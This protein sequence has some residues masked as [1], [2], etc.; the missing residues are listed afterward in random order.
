MGLARTGV[1][2]LVDKAETVGFGPEVLAELVRGSP[3]SLE[4]AAATLETFDVVVIQ[5][6]FGIYGGADGSEILDLMRRLS[7][8]VITVLHTVPRSPTPGQ[9]AIVEELSAAAAVVVAQSAAAKSRLLEAHS[10]PARHVR[11]IP[12]GAP[13]NLSPPGGSGSRRPIILSWGLLDRGK[14]IEYGIEAISHL[15]NLDPSP[16]YVVRGQTH[17]HALAREGEAYRELLHAQV[18][19]LGIEDLVE[20]YDSYDDTASVLAR[21][22]EA[23]VVLLPYRSRDQV[24]SGVLVEALASGKPVVATRFPHAVELLRDGSGIVVPH[25]DSPAIAAALRTLVTDP[26]AA[27]HAAAAARRQAPTFFWKNVGRMY[28]DLA[29]SVMRTRVAA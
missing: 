25:N 6:E 22:R 8:P 28:R 26:S 20:F 4:R 13:F 5:H 7:P 14:G 2:A 3:E 19:A 27:A 23:D 12:H 21:V 24:V 29:A 15:R 9:H 1:V 16:R 11:V 18:D 10:I 17:P